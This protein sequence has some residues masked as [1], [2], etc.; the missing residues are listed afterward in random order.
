MPFVGNEKQLQT[1]EYLDYDNTAYT[2]LHRADSEW[3]CLSFDW[4]SG[5]TSDKLAYNNYSPSIV[6]DFEYPM[7]LYSVAGSQAGLPS[8]NKIYVLRFAN[9]MK[10]KFDDDPEHEDEFNEKELN[11]G[12]PIILHR[13]IP[14][15]GGINRIRSMQGYP[16]VAL[17]SEAR[18]I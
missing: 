11:E 9:L 1:D 3:P 16:I 6:K 8:K 14:I 2:M 17:W 15:K 12:N 18:S 5:E 4:L 7:D 10:T 13:S